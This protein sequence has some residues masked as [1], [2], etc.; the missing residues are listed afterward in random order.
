MIL[1]KFVGLS[2]TTIFSQT[3]FRDI[4]DAIEDATIASDPGGYNSTITRYTEN[5]V[6]RKIALHDKEE[7]DG[8]GI[9]MANFD[10]L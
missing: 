1:L 8:G 9:S 4:C 10:T 2:H 5:M 3:S 7:H 6:Q